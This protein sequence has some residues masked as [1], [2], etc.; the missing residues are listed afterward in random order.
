LVIVSV[1]SSKTLSKTGTY[2]TA[3]LVTLLQKL[4]INVKKSSAVNT[5]KQKGRRELR[6]RNHWEK[7]LIADCLH[8]YRFLLKSV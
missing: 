2:K 8:L 1:H 6:G 7:I 3:C 5:E 4:Y